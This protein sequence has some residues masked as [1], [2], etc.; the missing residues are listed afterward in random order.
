MSYIC[1]Y[2]NLIMTKEEI[3]L[4]F[5]EEVL[6]PDFRAKTGVSR[7]ALYNYKRREIPNKLGV[8][9]ELLMSCDAIEVIKK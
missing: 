7:Q 5:K 2:A 4:L 8:I 6:K 1:F 9:V 3:I